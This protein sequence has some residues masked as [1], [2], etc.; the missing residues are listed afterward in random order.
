ML[1]ILPLL[2]VVPF[3]PCLWLSLHSLIHHL[4]H[5]AIPSTDVL[6]TISALYACQ[7]SC[8]CR[9]EKSPYQIPLSLVP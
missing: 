9:A 4:N 6:I 5:P 8:P 1:P 7:P 3:L 2:F